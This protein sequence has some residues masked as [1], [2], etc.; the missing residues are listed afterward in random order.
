MEGVMIIDLDSGTLLW[1]K[2]LGK[3]FGLR[4]PPR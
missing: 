4:G 3:N 2:S 1:S